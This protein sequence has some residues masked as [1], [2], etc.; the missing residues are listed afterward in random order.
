MRPRVISLLAAGGA[1]SLFVAVLA[2]V[3]GAGRAESP[4]PSPTI[5]SIGGAKVTT[6]PPPTRAVV[7]S[8]FPDPD[9]IKVGNT[10]YAYATN[11]N[12]VRLPIATASSLGGPWT[13]QVGDGLAGLGA[14]A[15]E[16]HTWA[17]DVSPRGDGTFLLYYTARLKNTEDQCIGV[18]VAASPLGPFDPVGAEPLICPLG[19]GGAIDPAAFVDTD[20]TRYLLFKSDSFSALHPAAIYLQRMSAD[21][22]RPEGSPRR[23]LVRDREPT[24]IEAPAMVKRGGKYVLF[25]ASGVFFNSSYRTGYAEASS[26]IGPYVKADRSLLS[27]DGYRDKV[28][29][30]GGADIVADANGDHIVFHGIL[31]FLGGRRVIRGMFVA[32]LAWANGRP[33]VRGSPTRYEAERGRLDNCIARAERTASA[34]AAVG[35]L[36]YPDSGVAVSVYAPAA[37][38][39]AVRV[40]YANRGTRPA[41]HGLRV[42]GAAVATL[43]YSAVHAGQWRTTT[44]VHVALRAGWNTLYVHRVTGQA[45]LDYIEVA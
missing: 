32:D 31:G 17:P 2:V 11:D 21:G 4:R 19:H 27:T 15:A 23:I 10:Y 28:I 29:G 39:Y 24:L 25:Y 12:G 37:G 13:R 45:E 7:T 30:P 35:Y 40:R 1:V 5:V 33:V 36:D 8:N 6:V 42:N 22:L 38:G 41:A 18:A 3:I 26:I 43:T 34:D 20:G 44:A 14:W 9:V 16:G